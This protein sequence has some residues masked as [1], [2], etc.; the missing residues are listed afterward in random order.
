MR[1]IEGGEDE[2]KW[3]VCDQN[4]KKGN[5][6]RDLRMDLVKEIIVQYGSCQRRGNCEKILKKP[7]TFFFFL[8]LFG[9]KNKHEFDELT[10]RRRIKSGEKS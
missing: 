2:E 1:Q 6:T 9:L 7:K 3:G 8:F 5:K 10:E 4:E